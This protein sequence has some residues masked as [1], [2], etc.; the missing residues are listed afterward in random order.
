MG[1]MA[2]CFTLSFLFD[3]MIRRV[4]VAGWVTVTVVVAV[5]AVPLLESAGRVA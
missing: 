2:I 5:L 4:R 1:T 3:R